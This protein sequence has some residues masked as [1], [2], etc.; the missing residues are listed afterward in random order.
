M[1]S[2]PQCLKCQY[3]HVRKLS[4]VYQEGR[5]HGRGQ[6]QTEL[7]RSAA[8]PK[9]RSS[10]PFV[11]IVL[12]ILL[13]A[14]GILEPSAGLITFSVILLLL[15]GT[16]FRSAVRHNREL[17]QLLERWHAS[18]LCSRCGVIFEHNGTPATEVAEHP[19]EQDTEDPRIIAATELAAVLLSST[20]DSKLHDTVH[21]AVAQL[22]KD[23]RT[24][25][26]LQLADHTIGSSSLT[27]GAGDILHAQ[28]R[29]QLRITQILEQLSGLSAA[30]GVRSSNFDATLDVLTDTI[31][32]LSAE[33]EVEDLLR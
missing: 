14:A 31:R 8:P 19:Q 6:Q 16:R 10:A 23:V 17:P 27:R 1:N 33:Q 26:A 2:A 11:G 30:T 28:Q 32:R 29:I 18:Y 22:K 12:A 4:L 13:L 20:A 24:L 3:T 5:S 21:S 9:E 15:F 7:S 25:H